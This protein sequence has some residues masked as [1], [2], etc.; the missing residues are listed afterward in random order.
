MNESEEE[1]VLLIGED[2][3]KNIGEQIAEIVRQ[4]DLQN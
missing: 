2:S 3:L 4:H 1:L